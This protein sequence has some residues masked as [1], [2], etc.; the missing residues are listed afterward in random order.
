MRTFLALLG[1]P[2][3]DPRRIAIGVALLAGALIFVV[4]ALVRLVDA[5][6]YALLR[7]VDPGLA[8]LLTGLIVL[9]VAGGLL[10]L[11]VYYLRPRRVDASAAAAGAGAEMVA[12]VLGLVRRHPTTAA[13]ATVLLGFVVG[14][15]SE[16][17][18]TLSELLR[19]A[20]EESDEK[21]G[22]GA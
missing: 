17:R 7:L 4:V 5:L 20:D 16:A 19:A 12:Q 13:L 10:G 9:L 6:E 11:A 22:G 8:A 15:R 2:G 1:L 3:F 21:S 18:R 14:S